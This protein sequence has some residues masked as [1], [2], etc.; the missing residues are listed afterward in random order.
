MGCGSSCSTAATTTSSKARYRSGAPD[1]RCHLCKRDGAFCL[2]TGEKHGK[3]RGEPETE[4]ERCDRIYLMGIYDSGTVLPKLLYYVKAGVDLDYWWEGRIQNTMRFFLSQKPGETDLHISCKLGA[5]DEDSDRIA[6]SCV[7]RILLHSTSSQVLGFSLIFNEES[8]S[9]THKIFHS[10]LKLRATTVTE[11]EAWV[12]T[13]SSS[14]DIPPQWEQRMDLSKCDLNTLSAEELLAC[15]YHHIQPD[16]F[17]Q[18]TNFITKKRNEIRKH[19]CVSNSI[20]QGVV[21]PIIKKGA[22]LVTKGELRYWADL[23]IFRTC[24]VWQLLSRADVI[25]DAGYTW[26]T[27]AFEIFPAWCWSQKTFRDASSRLKHLIISVM[28]IQRCR[29]LEANYILPDELLWI[30]FVH[31]PLY[32]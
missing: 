3:K 14:A 16:M 18:I 29:E 9:E 10:T 31:L 19:P 7:E 11:L 27:P 24:V 22:L 8:E 4:E 13:L 25:Y 26:P 17:R 28:K 12:I 23:D 15:S 6:V 5:D 20:K 32:P 1:V 21:P 2:I 30:I